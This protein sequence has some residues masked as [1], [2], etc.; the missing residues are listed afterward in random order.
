MKIREELGIL[1]ISININKIINEIVQRVLVEVSSQNPKVVST[2][3]TDM[4]HT[5]DISTM[6]LST[7]S[8]NCLHNSGLQTVGDV[9]NLSPR[10]LLRINNIGRK[11]FNEIIQALSKMGLTLKI[12]K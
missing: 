5:V 4:R 7:R 1:T 11:S 12:D 2:D 3:G 9:I 10:D 8:L 6:D